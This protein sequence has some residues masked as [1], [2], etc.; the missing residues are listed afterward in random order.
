ME[1]RAGDRAARR[2]FT[3]LL[4]QARGSLR[5]DAAPSGSGPAPFDLPGLWKAR[6]TALEAAAPVAELAVPAGAGIRRLAGR[7]RQERRRARQ[8]P[9]RAEPLCF[10]AG[11]CAGNDDHG[12]ESLPGCPQDRLCAPGCRRMRAP[13]CDEIHV[14]AQLR[15]CGPPASVP[16][17]HHLHH[18]RGRHLPSARGSSVTRLQQLGAFCATPIWV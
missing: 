6:V 1:R 14:P 13:P 2:D 3:A 7:Q 5:V 18:F 11:L 4:K 16:V 8:Y 12:I 15:Q 9:P 10:R 17:A